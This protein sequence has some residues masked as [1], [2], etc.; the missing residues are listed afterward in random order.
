MINRSNSSTL[1]L[2][3]SLAGAAFAQSAT[4]TSA[5]EAEKSETFALPAFTVSTARENGWRATNTMAGTRTNVALIDLPRSVSVLTSDFIQDVGARTVEEALPYVANATIQGGYINIFD[6]SSF[7]LRGFRIQN[8]YRNGAKLALGAAPETAVM[9][10]VEVLKGPASLLSGVSEPG[11]SLNY[12]TKRPQSTRR[13]K[14]HATYG[15]DEF[16][17]AGVDATGPVSKSVAYRLIYDYVDDQGF[18]AFERNE[19]HLLAPSLAWQITPKTVLTLEY[20][21]SRS[22]KTPAMPFTLFGNPATGYYDGVGVPWDFNDYGPDDLRNDIANYYGA[23]LQHQFN[24]T[25]SFRFN[26]LDFNND[27][28]QYSHTGTVRFNGTL[29]LTRPSQAATLRYL[30]Q[31]STNYQAD[32][33]A[34]LRYTPLFKHDIV[35]GGES[36]QLRDYQ[37]IYANIALPNAIPGTDN[38]Y[39][40]LPPRSAFTTIGTNSRTKADR[41]AVSAVNQF[42]FFEDRVLASYG[43]RYDRGETTSVNQVSGVT[44]VFKDHATTQYGGL[45]VKPLPRL[46]LYASYSESFSGTPTQRD[47]FSNPLDK[48]VGGEGTD[49]GVKGELF[50]SK[51]TFSA[52]VFTVDRTNVVRQLSQDELRAI[53][54]IPQ[55]NPVPTDAR[56]TQDA[57]QRNK[58]YEFEIGWQPVREYQ[59]AF[60]YGYV[61][62]VISSN[63]QFPNTVG[64]RVPEVGEVLWGFFHKYTFTKGLLKNLSLTNG[65]TY[66]D[67]ERRFS[68]NNTTGGTEF[69]IPGY[70]RYDL[71]ASYRT[72]VLGRETT[73]SLKANNV[74]DEQY[75]E[76]RQSKGRPRNIRISV[77]TLF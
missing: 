38:G 77:E 18:R 53:L 7:Y 75:F 16:F 48:P 64:Q 62:A 66:V 12:L 29:P 61:D 5:P 8:I 26:F 47:A 72:K 45:V 6:N 41:T 14:V 73:F 23:E 63:P 2:F 37:F 20:N 52:A 21:Y 40:N 22:E 56:F 68:L 36:L 57:G 49:F 30:T 50:D 60:N 24:D 28:E 76:G 11:G 74:G 67:G 51:L 31:G 10:R 34:K 17:S 58:G 1:W 69:L 71:G 39:R 15:D 65:I 19:R 9:E 46:S 27:I 54:N 44:T 3:L 33:V 35:V 55:P 42:A 4:Q 70:T 13:A 32:L 25:F 59:L 43:A